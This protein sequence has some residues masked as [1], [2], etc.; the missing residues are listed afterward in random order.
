MQKV[1]IALAGAA[2]LLTGAASNAQAEFIACIYQSGADVVVTGGGT[3]DVTG[4]SYVAPKDAIASV[5]GSTAN[6]FIRQATTIPVNVY[7]GVN[8]PTSFRSGLNAL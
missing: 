4:L 7:S 6:L 1:G 3:L 2:F 8:G 5:E